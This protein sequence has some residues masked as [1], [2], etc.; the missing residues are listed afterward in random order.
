M[1][2]LAALVAWSLAVGCAH[3]PPLPADRR[4]VLVTID[5]VRWQEVFRGAEPAMAPPLLEGFDWPELHALFRGAAERRRRAL[6][7]FVWETVAGH[8]RLFG[9]VDRGSRVVVAN[10]YRKSYPGYHELLCGFPSTTIT[11]NS[12]IPNPDATVLEWLGARPGFQGRVAAYASWNVF[13]SILNPARSRLYVNLG[14]PL[15]RPSV[16]DRLREE[17]RPPW[18]DSIHDAFVV[19]GA[20]AYLEEKQPRVLF[21]GLGDTDEWAHAGRYDRYL[22]ALHRADG[23]LRELWERVQQMEAYRGHTSLVITADHG[24]G[25]DGETWRGHGG[26]VAGADQGWV[27]VLGP[28]SAGGGEAHDHPPLGLAQVAA[29]IGALAGEDY[30]GAVPA[31]APPLPVLGG[32][33]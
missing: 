20:L 11:D 22:E 9:N 16:L 10:P 13:A 28:Y 31:A 17:I 29:T 1:R 2:T 25:A 6:M 18:R 15:G 33:R 21:V 3:K 12:R 7:P 24:R 14:E 32:T 8:G 23:W 27:A 4:V 30:A 19:Q 26:D 5:G